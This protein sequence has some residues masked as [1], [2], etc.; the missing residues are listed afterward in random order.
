MWV[1]WKSGVLQDCEINGHPLGCE[2]RFYEEGDLLLSRVFETLALAEIE[3]NDRRR[4]LLADGWS[5][6]PPMPP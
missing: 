3:A 5:E 4:E 2:V 1:L 6:R